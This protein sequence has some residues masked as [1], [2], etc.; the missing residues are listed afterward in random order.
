MIGNEIRI[1]DTNLI[2]SKAKSRIHVVIV[3]IID[4]IQYVDFAH[5]NAA[6]YKNLKRTHVTDKQKT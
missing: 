3:V 4:F 2:D 1:L 6:D 5:R